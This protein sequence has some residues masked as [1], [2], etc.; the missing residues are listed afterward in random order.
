MT[1]ATWQTMLWHFYLFLYENVFLLSLYR[2]YW[3]KAPGKS[4]E[5]SIFEPKENQL[6]II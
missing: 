6:I 2:E 4:Y 5:R 1:Y 3:D